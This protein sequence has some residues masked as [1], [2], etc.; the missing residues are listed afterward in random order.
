M[1]DSEK[2]K[3]DTDFGMQFLKW[4]WIIAVMLMFIGAIK[5]FTLN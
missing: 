2:E 3:I 4:F 1:E 5:C